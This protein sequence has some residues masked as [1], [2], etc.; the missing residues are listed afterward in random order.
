MAGYMERVALVALGPS[1]KD[2]LMK[3]E[4]AGG[5]A[6]LYDLIWHMD[7]MRVQEAR[8]E[9]GNSKI[10]GMLNWMKKHPGP[11]M[12]SRAY[13]D[14]PGLIEYPLQHVIR[15]TG[16]AYFNSTVAYAVAYAIHIGVKEMSLFG[17]DFTWPNVHAAE[18]GR[19]C[20]EFW[21]GQAMAR[22]MIIHIA[23]SST[24][25]DAVEP[26]ARR[27]YGY[28]TREVRISAPDGRPKVSF[29]EKPAPSAAEIEQ[30]Y[31]HNVIAFKN[32]ADHAALHD[33]LKSM[34][35][36]INGAEGK[37]FPLG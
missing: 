8:A 24:L 20:V 15:S 18:A 36:E 12:T 9:A 10:K 30:R 4:I 34:P 19:A 6:N 16:T 31:S 33:A 23:E 1:H 29:I 3:T 11:I 28:D 35:Y 7:D 5:R 2:Y 21:I 14:Y 32:G 25:M 27:F 22:G 26:E 37:S 17:V 13:A